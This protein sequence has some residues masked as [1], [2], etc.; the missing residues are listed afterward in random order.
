MKDK[1]DPSALL[2]PFDLGINLLDKALK[3]HMEWCEAAVV[4]QEKAYAGMLHAMGNCCTHLLKMDPERADEFL[5]VL[6]VTVLEDE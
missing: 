1:Q 2:N 6:R 3:D 4:D 5:S